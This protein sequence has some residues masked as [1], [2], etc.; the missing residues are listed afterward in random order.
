MVHFSKW[1]RDF[2]SY[3]ECPQSL[4]YKGHQRLFV[5]AYSSQDMNLVI[6]LHL[7]LSLRMHGDVIPLPNMPKWHHFAL[8]F[9]VRILLQF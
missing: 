8:E 2:F 5:Q 7:M 3:P 4:L 6:Q 9:N 1:K